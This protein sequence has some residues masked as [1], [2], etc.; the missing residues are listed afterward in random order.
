MALMSN[1]TNRTTFGEFLPEWYESAV[2]ETYQTGRRS[3]GG[4][5]EMT[6]TTTVFGTGG[7]HIEVVDE[8][9]LGYWGSDRAC[10]ELTN[11]AAAMLQ[12]VWGDS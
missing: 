5:W 3:P 7:P 12:S 1:S 8:T 6:S 9:V 4:E 2:L 11:A 10:Y